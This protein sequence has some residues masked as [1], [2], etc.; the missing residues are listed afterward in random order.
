VVEPLVAL[1]CF[2]PAADRASQEGCLG[3]VGFNRGLL[4]LEGVMIRRTREGRLT[5][6][7]PK[8]RDKHGRLQDIV[9]PVSQEARDLIEREVFAALRI[10][11]EAGSIRLEGVDLTSTAVQP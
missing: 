9:H 7:F 5:L 2:R 3:H 6:S 11:V 8:R 4:R 10:A 1:V